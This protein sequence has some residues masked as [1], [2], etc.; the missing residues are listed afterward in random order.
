MTKEINV[1]V[2]TIEIEARDLH[3]RGLE[4]WEVVVE[5]MKVFSS[6]VIIKWIE[7]QQ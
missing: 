1:S 2:R 6:E 3:K 4:R 7:R 5:L